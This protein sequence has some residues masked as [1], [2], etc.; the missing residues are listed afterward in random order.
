M[1][2][3][4]I[5]NK[6]NTSLFEKEFQIF[7]IKWNK[8]TRL[9]KMPNAVEIMLLTNAFECN[10]RFCREMLPKYITIQPSY[11]NNNRIK[12]EGAYNC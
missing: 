9:E 1:C 5:Y 3:L 7:F 4:E 6:Y 10:Q 11:R 8:I 12:K 2:L